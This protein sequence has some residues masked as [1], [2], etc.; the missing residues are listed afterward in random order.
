MRVWGGSH[1]LLTETN[2]PGAIDWTRAAD[3]L[4]RPQAPLKEEGG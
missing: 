2:I 1:R 4:T 3:Q